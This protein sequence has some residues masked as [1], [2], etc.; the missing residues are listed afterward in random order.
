MCIRDSEE[1]GQPI[2]PEQDQPRVRADQEARPER[3]DEQDDEQ[4]L[5]LPGA[6][7]DEVGERQSNEQAQDRARDRQVEAGDERFGAA[8][9]ALV[10]GEREA[11]RVTT[12][13]TPIAEAE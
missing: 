4:S 9:R 12:R 2:T 10:I 1:P 5:A 8:K 7:R 11:A 6:G 13:V 3:D